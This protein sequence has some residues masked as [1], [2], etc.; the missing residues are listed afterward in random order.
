MKLHSGS[1]RR[2]LAVTASAGTSRMRDT[3]SKVGNHRVHVGE[4]NG[5]VVC[6]P[7]ILA[8]SIWRAVTAKCEAIDVWR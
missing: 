5:K 4:G 7:T 1:H 3:L 6:A 8:S 2:S